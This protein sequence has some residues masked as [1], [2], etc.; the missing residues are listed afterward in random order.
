M[1]DWL[2]LSFTYCYVFS[3]YDRLIRVSLEVCWGTLVVTGLLAENHCFYTSLIYNWLS[4]INIITVKFC[5][6]CFC[7]TCVLY[8]SVYKRR[9]E[10]WRDPPWLLP[11]SFLLWVTILLA[12]F[13]V[14]LS[15]RPPLAPPWFCPLAAPPLSLPLLSLSDLVSVW[16]WWTVFLM[17]LYYVIPRVS[18]WFPL[19]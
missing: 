12:G 13:W 4:I 8:T 11:P 2:I 3:F 15:S 6:F 5:N 1:S 10:F 14:A 7:Y 17:C 18:C 16:F 19:L 9:L